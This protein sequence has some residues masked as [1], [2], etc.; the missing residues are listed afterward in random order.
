MNAMHN[1]A[2]AGAVYQVSN[3]LLHSEPTN[4]II[5]TLLLLG[6]NITSINKYN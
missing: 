2:W 4:D 1:F 3:L 5:L 6:V